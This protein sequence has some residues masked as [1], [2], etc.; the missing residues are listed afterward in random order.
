LSVIR[1]T[2]T[3][4]ICQTGSRISSQKLVIAMAPI[5]PATASQRSVT[6]SSRFLRLVISWIDTGVEL[7]AVLGGLAGGQGGRCPTL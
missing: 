6:S 4:A 5:C 7:K 3:A 1:N 2:I